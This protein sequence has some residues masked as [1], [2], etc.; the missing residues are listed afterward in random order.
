MANLGYILKE[1]VMSA[2]KTMT[3]KE[4]RDLVTG[5]FNYSAY[6]EIPQFDSALANAI[7]EMEKP[8]I[9]YNLKKWQERSTLY[10]RNN[11]DW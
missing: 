11:N 2:S 8:A 1:S 7:F 3:D 10:D 6:G 4:F 9:D 5:L